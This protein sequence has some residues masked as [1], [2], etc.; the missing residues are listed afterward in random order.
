M[1]YDII[2]ST[3]LNFQTEHELGFNNIEL[4]TLVNYIKSNVNV[5]NEMLFEEALNGITCAT[6]PKGI[7]IYPIDII[8]AI[9]CAVNDR[10]LSKYEWD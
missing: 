10:K 3:V 9:S 8:K 4:Q 1:N 5:F 2:E 7:V 6:G